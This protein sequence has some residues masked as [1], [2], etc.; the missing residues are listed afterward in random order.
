MSLLHKDVKEAVH[1]LYAKDTQ[2]RYEFLA[3]IKKLNKEMFI[4]VSKDIKAFGELKEKAQAA[5]ETY[6]YSV[7]LEEEMQK[8]ALSKF[9]KTDEAIFFIGKGLNSEDWWS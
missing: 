5:G 6:K 3:N 8:I 9:E 7:I 1:M 4:Q 2:E